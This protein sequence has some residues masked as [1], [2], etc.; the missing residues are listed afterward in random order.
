MEIMM[1]MILTT[2]WPLCNIGD[3]Y[4]DYDDIPIVE[5]TSIGLVLFTFMQNLKL[6]II[7]PICLFGS[8]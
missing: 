4:D 2:L 5:D 6:V 7:L 8:V 1:M 3:H